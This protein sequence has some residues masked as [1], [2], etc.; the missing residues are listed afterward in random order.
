MAK[1]KTLTQE[2]KKKQQLDNCYN[3]MK[4]NS[5]HPLEKAPLTPLKSEIR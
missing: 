5:K 2:E 4:L 3:L 1:V